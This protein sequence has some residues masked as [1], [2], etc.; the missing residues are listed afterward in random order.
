MTDNLTCYVLRHTNGR[1]VAIDQPSGGYP[2]LVTEFLRAERFATFEEAFNYKGVFSKN[3]FDS[4][5]WRIVRW[6][7]TQLVVSLSTYLKDP[8]T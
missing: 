8:D 2:Y 4:D 6:E 5:N 7:I 3:Q 1:Y